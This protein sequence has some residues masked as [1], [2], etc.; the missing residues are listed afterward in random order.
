M[1][2]KIKILLA[3]VFIGLLIASI[4][5]FVRP[6]PSDIIITYAGR[7]PNNTNKLFF[8]FT[9]ASGETMCCFLYIH[10]ATNRYDVGYSRDHRLDSFFFPAQSQTNF[11][12]NVRQQEYWRVVANYYPAYPYTAVQRTRLRLSDAAFRQGWLTLSGWLVPK[13]QP[14]DASG[15]LMF[16]DKPAPDTAKPSVP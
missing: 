10:L 3:V 2:R 9:N 8:N 6:K 7:S 11:A 5:F 13:A 1:T 15:P 16:E 12:F 4:F 14:R